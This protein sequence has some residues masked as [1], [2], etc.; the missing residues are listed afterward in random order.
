MDTFFRFFDF[1]SRL[2]L[3]KIDFLKRKIYGNEKNFA[4]RRNGITSF[5]SKIKE[6]EVCF[7]YTFRFPMTQFLIFLVA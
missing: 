4:T 3:K 7:G 6:E 5:F 2:D 1:N